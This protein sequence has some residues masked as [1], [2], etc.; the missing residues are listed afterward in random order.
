[1]PTI[2]IELTNHAIDRF[3]ERV[4]PGLARA[5]AEVEL[6]RLALFGAM[7]ADPPPWYSPCED[8]EASAY[9]VIGDL[10]LPLRAGDDGVHV[11]VT[12]IARGGI[13]PAARA[14]RRLHGQRSLRGQRRPHWTNGG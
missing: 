5:S 11:A 6:A 8:H 10:V 3:H 4:R 2:E 1:M 14:R 12:C 9:L 7:V 13:S